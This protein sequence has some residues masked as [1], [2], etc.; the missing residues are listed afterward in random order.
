MKFPLQKIKP[1]INN[2]S[3]YLTKFEKEFY[4]DDNLKTSGNIILMRRFYKQNQLLS[5]RIID[6]RY[7]IKLSTGFFYF[8]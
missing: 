5:E 7:F 2:V 4:Y 8:L 6:Y 1:T 3:K